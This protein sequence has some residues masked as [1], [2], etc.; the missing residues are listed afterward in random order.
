M[1]GVCVV[2][3]HTVWGRECG[4]VVID[5]NISETSMQPGYLPVKTAVSVNW[6]LDIMV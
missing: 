6:T 2:S 1:C 4:G 3:P 5:F